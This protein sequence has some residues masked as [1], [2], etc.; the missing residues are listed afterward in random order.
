[1]SWVFVEYAMGLQNFEFFL[2]LR[3]ISDLSQTYLRLIS[4]IST[5][6]T[7]QVLFLPVVCKAQGNFQQYIP[8][9]SQYIPGLGLSKRAYQSMVTAGNP[10]KSWENDG[11]SMG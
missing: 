10:Q 3:L 9:I 11:H 4:V 1:M 2:A 6:S 8:D 5:F 7:T